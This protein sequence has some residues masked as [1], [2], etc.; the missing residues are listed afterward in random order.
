[1]ARWLEF[2]LSIL[3]L[4]GDRPAA[5]RVTRTETGVTLDFPLPP[6]ERALAD[7]RAWRLYCVAIVLLLSSIVW[8]AACSAVHWFD[9]RWVGLLPFIAGLGGLVGAVTLSSSGRGYR[10]GSDDVRQLAVIGNLLIRTARDHRKQLWYCHEVLAITIEDTRVI[11][12]LANG[13]K[14]VLLSQPA[15]VVGSKAE[16]ESIVAELRQ[17]IAAAAPQPTASAPDHAIQSAEDFASRNQI[18]R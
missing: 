8:F 1:M 13:E 4:G 11:V 9:Q 2:V 10:N 18:T 5:P 12:E 15:G 16:L 6:D 17:A 14:A 3:G 7:A